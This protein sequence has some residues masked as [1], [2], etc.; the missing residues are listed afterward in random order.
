MVG[1]PVFF[2]T[3][4]K[5]TAWGL[6]LIGKMVLEWK[7]SPF[8]STM[9]PVILYLDKSTVSLNYCLKSI[10]I[11]YQEFYVSVSDDTRMITALKD[12]LPELEKTMKQL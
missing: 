7:T 10:F 6:F 9:V 2:S 8:L 12:Q 1:V 4:G 5:S 3:G 11:I